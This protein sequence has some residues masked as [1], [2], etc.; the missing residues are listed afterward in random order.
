M[1]VHLG[2][3]GQHFHVTETFG[4]GSL[5]LFFLLLFH[6]RI[7]LDQLFGFLLYLLV[8]FLAHLFLHDLVLLQLL[9]QF[10]AGPVLFLLDEEDLFPKRYGE[11][12]HFAQKPC[13]EDDVLCVWNI[14]HTIRHQMQFVVVNK[15]GNKSTDKKQALSQLKIFH[16]RMLHFKY[17][18]NEQG[19]VKRKDNEADN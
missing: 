19:N 17:N 8:Q 14:E 15:G 10:L 12:E 11:A 9:D 1:G 4:K 5:D 6:F 2:A 18:P 16:E 7:E 3:Q 13:L